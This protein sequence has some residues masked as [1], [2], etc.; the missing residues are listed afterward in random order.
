MYS[1]FQTFNLAR[2]PAWRSDRT[3]ELVDLGRRPSRSKDDEYVQKYHRFLLRER[4]V[5][6]EEEG[7]ELFERNPALYDAHGF[8]THRDIERRAFLQAMIVAGMADEEIA[9]RLACLPA[10]VDWYEQ[11]FFNVRGRLQNEIWV[12]KTIRGPRHIP[13]FNQDGSLTVR[14]RAIGIK[15]LSY[16]GGPLI[17]DSAISSLAP[18]LTPG[19]D[20]DVT[21]WFDESLRLRIKTLATIAVANVGELDTIKLFR[22][23]LRTA[24][25]KRNDKS[26]DVDVERNVKAFFDHLPKDWGD[27]I[28]D[29]VRKKDLV[30]R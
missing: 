14:G 1:G 8:H 21:A 23:N 20:P 16:W 24:A 11:V 2:P 13:R 10:T 4:D 27:E 22:Q 6:S 18:R 7:V 12:N 9:K 30:T 19:P 25:E 29:D 26:S 28:D 5:L 15:L 17:V 3:L